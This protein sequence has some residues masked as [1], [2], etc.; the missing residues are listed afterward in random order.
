MSISTKNRFCSIFLIAILVI[1]GISILLN[2][3]LD[4][5]TVSA[6]TIIVDQGSGG[7]YTTIQAAINAA[8]PGDTIYIWAGTYPENI[9]VNKQV[10]LIGNG[11]IN[12]TIDGGGTGDV[13]YITAASVNIK[14]IKTTNSG[15]TSTDYGIEIESSN[16]V[17]IENCNSS[18]NSRGIYISNS[19]F[20]VLLNNTCI[21]NSIGIRNKS[22]NWGIIENNTV[23]SNNEWGIIARSSHDF[24]INNNTLISNYKGAIYLIWSRDSIVLNNSMTNC[25]IFIGGSQLMEWNRYTIDTNN[26]VNSKPVYYWKDRNGGTVP[27]DAGEVILANC[28]N[29]I[30]ENLNV[31]NSN[32]ISLGF[33]DANEIRNNTIN[34]NKWAGI[35]LDNSDN[36]IIDNNTCSYNQENGIDMMDSHSNIIS[37]NTCNYNIYGTYNLRGIHMSYSNFNRVTNNTCNG[38]RF[39][40]EID[41]NS[42]ACIVKNNNCDFNI[43][44]GINLV[45]GGIIENNTCNFNKN[46]IELA[47]T[48][49]N[50]VRNNSFSG[51][52]HGIYVRASSNSNTIINNTIF[53]NNIGLNI[54]SS[55]NNIFYHNNIYSNTLQAL[56]DSTNQWDNG[57]GE[58]NYWSDYS[59]LDDG[60]GGR[61]VGDGIGD[62][63][64]LHL[65]LDNYPFLNPSGWLFPGSPNLLDPGNIDSD[66]DY[67]V[68]WNASRNTIGY[69]VE[70]AVNNNFNSPVEI[71]NGSDL[72]CDIFGKNNATYY[73]RVKAYNEKSVSGWSNIVDIIV[74]WLPDIPNNLFVAVYPEGN[75]LNLSWDL[76]LLDTKD[77]LLHHKTTGSWI[78]LDMIDH[79]AHTYNHTDLQDGQQYYYRIQA[80]DYLDQLSEFSGIVAAVPVDSIAPSRPK[81]L[82]YDVLSSDSILLDWDSNAEADIEGYNIYRSLESNP[83][84]WD[85][86]I[87]GL[88]LLEQSRY[89]DMGLEELT[90][91]YYV[92]TTLDEV[93]QESDY[94]A[95][96]NATTLL[97]EHGPELT[98]SI[99]DFTIHEDIYDDTS[100]DLYHW[101]KDINN[102]PLQFRC[103]GQEYLEVNI[104]SI[105]GTVT[106]KPS[107]N[108][109][110]D[111]ILTF[112][113]SDG[114]VE[115][116]DDVKIT[117]TAVN[118][119]PDPPVI[120]NPKN[121]TVI[122]DGDRLD[123]EGSGTDPDLIYG[124]GL[125]YNW[126]SNISGELGEGKTLS[127]LVLPIG[128]HLITL[129][130]IDKAA[131]TANTTIII[132]V[133]ETAQSDSDDD[134]LPN[135]WERTYGLDP[136]DSN[137][138]SEDS[139]HDGLSNSDEYSTGTDPQNNDSD[140]DLYND[141][142]DAYPLDPTR[143]SKDDGPQPPQT[144]GQPSEKDEDAAWMTIIAV[145]IIIIVLVIVI[146]M[147]VVRPKIV[148][149]SQEPAVVP[150]PV[151]PQPPA[152]ASQPPFPPLQAQ[153]PMPFPPPQPIPSTVMPM[154]IP[155]P[156]PPVIQPPQ[157]QLV[158]ETEELQATEE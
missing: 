100:I 132:T 78:F 71:Y 38:N 153:P 97:G 129:T 27:L 61:I 74:D 143:W 6:A 133:Q 29:V 83:I 30:I 67:T 98:N 135:I 93:P 128:S 35:W 89:I 31:S 110:G 42:G 19:D 158:T 82:V 90:T 7:D 137:D 141:K 85:V 152:A 21:N 112:F 48:A 88:T 47:F 124:D 33:S 120:I 75:A 73:Y 34:Y 46:G 139:D 146:F 123:F 108:W 115:I 103:E 37:N 22:S 156:Q 64:L 25:G 87:N 101:F 56:S 10:T 130:A 14:N 20:C 69:V 136:L 18:D 65:G 57:N 150:K 114:K 121:N 109:N 43:Y 68:S 70:E 28:Q 138:A 106:L 58:G 77:Y 113:A 24:T 60:S 80:R 147:F 66:G 117:V 131:K 111:E 154:P 79:P 63:N 84:D 17:K 134:G 5:T 52:T 41:T 76:N 149:K 94:S 140:G 49:V 12:T 39:G 13:I 151:A 118:D 157:P 54:S 53:N 72:S 125:T 102:D 142:I 36:N 99:T 15:P 95:E 3:G 9:V 148:K 144:N 107:L 155:P 51:N 40:I 86:P 91:Y 127:N 26:T 44:G 81:G 8:I 2:L 50:L 126:T 105:N 62:T 1:S 104:Y 59:G 45:G 92:V 11:T 23:N 145:I 32:G 96:V 122:D 119:P 4:N 55:P 116:F 16:N